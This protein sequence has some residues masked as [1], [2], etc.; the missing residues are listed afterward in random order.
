[1]IIEGIITTENED[2]TMHVSPIGPHVDRSLSEWKLKPFQSSHSFQNLVRSNRCVF[3][4]VDDPLLMAMSVLG[5]CNSPGATS[6]DSTAFSI[7]DSS[8]E[9]YAKVLQ[10]VLSDVRSSLFDPD[11]GWLLPKAIR[12]YALKI[13]EWDLSESRA[14]AICSVTKQQEIQPFWGW[15][16]G[17]Y[18]ILELAILASRIHMTEKAIIE[19][20]LAKHRIVIEKTGGLRE[21]AAFALLQRRMTPNESPT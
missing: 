12:R 8:G 6:L 17:A 13:Q 5:L 2:G 11:Q 18:S 1:M 9:P 21:R 14:L 4:V 20:E 3:H 10:E 15:C 7:A 19:S 16:R